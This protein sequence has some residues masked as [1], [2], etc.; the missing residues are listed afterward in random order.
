MI[1]FSRCAPLATRTWSV[2]RRG[3]SEEHLTVT[4]FKVKCEQERLAQLQEAAV[5]AQAEVDRKNR[6]GGSCREESGPSQGQTKR[7]GPHAERHGEAGG[8]IFQRPGTGLA[9]RP[10][11]KWAKI[12]KVLRSVYRA[13]LDLKSKFERLQ[14]DYGRE[15]SK[16]VP[17]QKGFTRSAP[18][19]TV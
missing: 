16:T 5:L 3:S 12:V 1:S 15:V 6:G 10:K 8:G 14:A 13:Y 19:E 18:R 7:C 9:K 11:K 4:Q 2:E 17:C